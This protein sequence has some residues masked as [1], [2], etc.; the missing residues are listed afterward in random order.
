[1]LLI[2]GIQEYK[3]SVILLFLF[4]KNYTNSDVP[5]YLG[6][7]FVR[8]EV[9]WF[10]FKTT[11][12]FLLF[13]WPS[14]FFRTEFLSHHLD[15]TLNSGLVLITDEAFEMPLNLSGTFIKQVGCFA[16]SEPGN[17]SDAGAASTTARKDGNDFI[18]DGTKSWITNGYE[19]EASV[20]LVT[21]DKNLKHKGI[22]N[23]CAVISKKVHFHCWL[24]DV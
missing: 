10:W 15:A 21:T 3:K 17:G 11:I 13:C 8:I 5:S 22:W 18:I 16:L 4:R 20:V 23:I 9:Q 7:N 1:M 2:K 12:Y 24:Y 14:G 6:E 19:S